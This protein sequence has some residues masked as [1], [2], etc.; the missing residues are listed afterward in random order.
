MYQHENKMTPAV[1]SVLRRAAEVTQA[2]KELATTPAHI[3]LAILETRDSAGVNMLRANDVSPNGLMND[4]LRIKDQKSKT[5]YASSLTPAAESVLGQAYHE[6]YASNI[7]F[8]SPNNVLIDVEHLILGMMVGGEDDA[9]RILINNKADL[10]KM[11]VW[12]LNKKHPTKPSA[13][14]KKIQAVEP[15]IT[16]DPES[17]TTTIEISKPAT[18]TVSLG[19]GSVGFTLLVPPMPPP[20]LLKDVLAGMATVESDYLQDAAVEEVHFLL[21]LTKRDNPAFQHVL[22]SLGITHRDILK[23]ILTTT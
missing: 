12:L 17:K 10:R 2:K 14:E 5:T 7:P 8:P 21:A 20:P 19:L 4:L 22:K 15:K 18:A 6:A 16:H 1:L 9:A 11:R 23:A 3:L 13:E